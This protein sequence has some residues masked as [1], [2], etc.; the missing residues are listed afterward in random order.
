M[1][2]RN[3]LLTIKLIFDA[4]WSSVCDVQTFALGLFLPHQWQSGARLS[5]PQIKRNEMQVSSLQS[6]P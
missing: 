5:F 1:F 6:A 2:S 3:N 4:V